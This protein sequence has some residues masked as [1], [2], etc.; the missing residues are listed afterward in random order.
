MLI[1]KIKILLCLLLLSL[2]VSGKSQGVSSGETYPYQDPKL[3][4]HDRVSDLVSRMTRAEKISQLGSNALSIPRLGVPAYNYWNEALH[5]VLAEGTTSFPQVIALSSTWDADLIFQVASAISDEARVKNHTDNTGMVYYSPTINMARDPRWGRTE[6]TYGE[7]PFLAGQLASGFIR[8]MQGN[9]AKY[10]KIS[11]TVKHFAC[12]NVDDNRHSISSNVDERS[13]REYYLPAFRAGVTKAGVLSVMNTYNSLNGVP[14]PVNSTLLKHIL[15]DE[16]G[17]TG[18]VVSDCDAVHDVFAFHNYVEGADDATALSLKSGTD[19]NCGGTYQVFSQAALDKGIMNVADIDTALTRIFKARFLLGEFDPPGMVPYT[20]IPDSAI[21]CLANRNLALKAAREAIVLL[22]NEH[23][24]LPLRAESI[25]RLAIIG[26]N[27]SLVQ[28]GAYSGFPVSTV[29][30]L[31]GLSDKFSAPG[32][33]IVFEEGCS[34]YGPKDQ[35]AFD[36]AV[37]LAATSDAVIFVGGTDRQSAGEEHD[38]TTLD[39]PAIQDS[40]IMAVL[41]ANPRTIVVL[42]TGFPL[43]IN[44]LRARVPGI[45]TAWYDGQSQGEAIADVVSGDFNPGGKL[46]STWYKSIADLPPMDHYDIK[47]N[48]T[49]QYFTGTPLFAFGHGLSYTTFSYSNLTQSRTTLNRG[50]SLIVGVTVKNTGD[51]AGDEVAQF[52]IHHVSTYVKRPLLELKGFRRITLQPGEAKTVTFVLKTEDLSWYDE[53]TRSFLVEEGMMDIM[54][55]S[56]SDDIRLESQVRVTGYVAGRAYTRKSL[57]VFEA[58]DFEKKSDP[59]AIV[60]NGAGGQS[61]MNGGQDDFAEYRNV[62]FGAGVEQMEALVKLEPSAGGEGF[63]EIRLDSLRGTLAGTLPLIFTDKGYVT[64]ICC[65]AGTAGIH[66]IFLVFKL[67]EPGACMVDR[68]TFSNSHC[69]PG[70]LPADIC[71]FPNPASEGFWLSGRRFDGSEMVIEIYATDGIL[72]K[73]YHAQVPPT[74]LDRFYISNADAGLTR[75]IYIIKCTN[76]HTSQSLKLS[77]VN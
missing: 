24:V 69:V 48:R 27:A 29:T 1:E 25:T 49:Y 63:L 28:L 31:K 4:V 57:S 73:T 68:F 12:N 50:D 21:N 6:E 53:K 76:S 51:V 42:V 35:A 44:L 36:R 33:T 56:S 14:G 74:G 15:R 16:W 10:L 55:G 60:S 71:L 46:T 5:G 18:F 13:L 32:K 64:K 77:V 26:P 72:K 41:L 65:M 75:G 3:P 17:F 67:T 20:F 61:I 30:P 54:T 66:D 52:Y 38:R 39:L 58:E 59:V 45:I 23:S 2:A 9:D 11:A 47:E 62:D 22:K 40:L 70:I 34:L 19:L 43:S 7:D 37:A 8:G